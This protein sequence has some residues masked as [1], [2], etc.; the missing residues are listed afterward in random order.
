MFQVFR[1]AMPSLLPTSDSRR[2]ASSLP[3]AFA[4]GLLLATLTAPVPAASQDTPKRP[5]ILLY[6]DMEGLSGIDR[7]EMTSFS[8]PEAYRI[9][10]E[11]LTEEVNAAIRGLVEGGA[12]SIRVVDSHAS[13]NTQEPDILLD[14]MDK[15]A[16]FEFRDTDFSGY[17]DM[18]GAGFDAIVCVGMHA[19]GRTLGFLAHTFTWEPS[20]RVNGR[21]ITETEIIAHF[22]APHGVPVVMVSGDDVLQKQIAERFPGAEFG[23]VK[24]ARGRA[25][26]D[27]LPLAE[28]RANVEAAARRAVAKIRT[29]RP[30]PVEPRF[31][32]EL[33]FQN[34]AQAERASVATGVQRASET[35]VKYASPTFRDGY[36]TTTGLIRLATAERMQLLLE[37]VRK[38]PDGQK[39]VED[40]QKAILD[41]FYEDAASPAA[42]APP[43]T[44]AKRRYWGA[45]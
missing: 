11:M 26:A 42:S 43:T 39:I 35:S 22:A 41:R 29:V 34:A 21:D 37:V 45:Q 12:G 9:G 27:L 16:T 1:I 15:R 17:R 31:E 36:N 23:L 38:H 19:R 24:R 32:W 18:P 33:G 20:W 10:R 6:Y 4:A 14:R 44:A 8:K 5:R 7:Q 30:F 28:A 25:H 2:P 40:W 13:G 3:I